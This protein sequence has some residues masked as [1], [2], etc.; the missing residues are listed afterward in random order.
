M[1]A[2]QQEQLKI[3]V[4]GET[5]AMA[6]MMIESLQQA[7]HVPVGSISPADDIVS[8]VNAG[9][10][11]V[12][13]AYMEQTNLAFMNQ[14]YM[15]NQETPRPVIIFTEKSESELIK[16]AV[17][18]GVSAFVVDG[19]SHHRIGPILELAVARF[20]EE[21]SLRDELQE[22]KTRLDERKVIEKAKGIIMSKRHL[23]ED[24]AYKALRKLA[25]DRNQKIAD[26]ARDVISVST[27]LN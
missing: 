19:Y 18:A 9:N 23:D 26:V 21:R 12:V 27:L 2:K 10:V 13:I 7:G 20:R 3:L 8:N 24:D 15:L 22:T 4:V 17:Q 6:G 5:D 11:D 14:I 25:M 1:P 16:G